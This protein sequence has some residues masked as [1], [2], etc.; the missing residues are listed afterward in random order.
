MLN[1]FFDQVLRRISVRAR[2]VGSFLLVMLLAGSVSPVILI[3][4]NTLVKRLEQ[5]TNVDARTERLLL[6]ASQRVSISQLELNRY[7]QDLLPG[8]Y[9]A[10][11]DANE[12]LLNL[13]EARDITTDAEQ[14]ENI[15]TVI[16]SLEI[17]RQQINNLQRAQVSG[18]NAEV[19]RLESNLQQLGNDISTR[20][21][22]MVNEN[23]AQ[24]LAANEKVLGDARQSINFGVVIVVTG[25]LLAILF[26]TLISISITKPLADL[27]TSAES[28]QQG[29]TDFVINTA[30][31]DE[32]TVIATMFSDL[33]KQVRELIYSLENRVMARTKELNNAVQY[34]EKRARQFEAVIKVSQSISTSTSLQELLPYISQVVSEQFGFYHVGIFL[35]DESNLYAI[36][37]AANS[38]GG[39]RMLMRGHQLKVGEQGIV[40]YVTSMG[41]PRIALDVGQDVTYFNNPDL[42]ETHSEMALPIVISGKVA[43]AL[44]IQSTESNAFSDEDLEVLSA[45]ANQVSL[46]IQNAR[47][48]DQTKKTLAEAEAIQRQYLQSTWNRLPQEEGFVGFHYSALGAAIIRTPEEL[49]E[50]NRMKRKTEIKVP[51]VLRGENIG[52]LSIQLPRHERI[53]SDQMDVIK[54]VAERV[55]LSAENARLFDE[56]ARRAERERIVSDISSKIGYS[57]QTETILQTAAKEISHLLEDTDIVI[58]LQPPQ[59]E[60]V[61]EA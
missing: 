6:V 21:E 47:L 19:T 60:K 9:A 40:G 29:Q 48:F 46:A 18:D 50:L 25:L 51:V 20:L 55:A 53:T 39:K 30:G 5:V 31:A 37:S 36:L 2:M 27:R 26:S 14:K 10:V 59:A 49:E 3:S 7:I 34:I 44:D 1:W 12:A 33:T 17:Y 32:F 23:A 52:M 54:A 35:N 28:F 4:L 58:K 41:E 45:L 15:N 42:P 61:S 22:V 57:F 43:G 24:V 13:K 8:P 11:D 38:P 56:T 16:R